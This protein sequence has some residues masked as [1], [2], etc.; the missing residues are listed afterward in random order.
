VCGPGINVMTRIHCVL[1]PSA[2]EFVA[3]CSALQQGGHSQSKSYNIRMPFNT[4][5]IMM[6]NVPNGR[7]VCS[8]HDR[9]VTTAPTRLHIV[10][11][12]IPPSCRNFALY[13]TQCDDCT[14]R[15]YV[16]ST[17]TCDRND[18]LGSSKHERCIG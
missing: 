10:R 6:S 1:S 16:D 15:R 4:R 8:L 2:V 7:E 13:L 11:C 3:D 18:L 9:K 17:T 14:D 5:Y 12:P